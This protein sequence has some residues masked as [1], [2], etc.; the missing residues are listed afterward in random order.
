MEARFQY[1]ITFMLRPLVPG[2]KMRIWLL[3]LHAFLILASKSAVAQDPVFSQFYANPIYLNPAFTGT[4][5]MPKVHLNFRD[6]WP[7]INHAYV[8]YAASYDQYFESFNSG[9]GVQF[10]GDNAGQGIYNTVAVGAIYAYQ[11]NFS[12]QFAMK[13][14]VQGDFHQKSLDFNK[15]RFYD[16]IDPVTGFYDAGNNL[17]PTGETAPFS[18]NVSYLDLHAG[19]LAFTERFFAGFAARHLNQPVESFRTDYSSVL[20]MRFTAHAGARLGD[21]ENDEESVTL[22]PNIMYTQQAEFKQ[23]NAGSYLKIGYFMGGVWYRYN[24]NY[25]DAVIFLLGVQKSLLTFGY[26]YDWTL[27]DLGGQTGGSHE[28][29]II[30][31]FDHLE[32]INSGRS[33]RESLRCPSLF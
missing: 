25:S 5:V 10:I 4:T 9:I 1:V 8:S 23:L 2:T 20:P 15:L 6:Q 16:Q 14:G 12:E 33:L 21:L 17:N 26:S 29:S 11:I 31:N 22:S 7:G 18:D 32:N 27:Q 13:I 28:V 24:I 30:L 19:V 3:L